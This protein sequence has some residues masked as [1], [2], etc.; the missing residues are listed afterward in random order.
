MNFKFETREQLLEL[1][2]KHST[3]VEIGVFKGDFSKIILE[4]VNPDKL[5]LVDPW[6]GVIESGDK[7]GQNIQYIDGERYYSDHI[8]K[9]FAT[10]VRVHVLRAFSTVLESFE[11]GY[12]DWAYVDGNH[13]YTSVKYDLDVSYRKVK[14]G[15]FILGHD[16][17]NN[18]FPGVVKAVDEFCTANNLTVDYLTK[19]G[20]PS[21]FI[22]TL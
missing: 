1:L 8:V 16:Y 14:K 21:Y 19:D 11:D 13:D 15:G 6:Q 17:N 3:G 4:V 2:P 18:N 9:E 5:Y 7:N 20:C 10:D 22:R 12:F